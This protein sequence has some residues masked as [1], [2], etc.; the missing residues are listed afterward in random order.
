MDNEQVDLAD[1]TKNFTNVLIAQSTNLV[2]QLHKVDPTS[3][4]LVSIQAAYEL[5]KYQVSRIND[6]STQQ[7]ILDII[8][9]DAENLVYP[10]N[11]NVGYIGNS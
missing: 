4:H 1:L 11:P 7:Q 8:K 9:L 10:Q 3:L 2:E 6:Q 5:F